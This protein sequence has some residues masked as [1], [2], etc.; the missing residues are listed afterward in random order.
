MLSTTPLV[1]PAGAASSPLSTMWK[2]PAARTAL[3]SA[4][5]GLPRTK[6]A[7]TL[8]YLLSWQQ[9]AA[10]SRLSRQA[11][12][13]HRVAS[14]GACPLLE[15]GTAALEVANK[16]SGSDASNSTG[17]EW[18]TA[19]CR[20]QNAAMNVRATLRTCMLARLHSH[21]RSH[22]TPLVVV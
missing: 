8:E 2:L 15:M 10:I 16:S 18:P 17:K 11:A 6:P 14:A 3:L 22:H 7:D 4:S 19:S 13:V 12:G 21:A 5:S 1:V 20:R 9:A